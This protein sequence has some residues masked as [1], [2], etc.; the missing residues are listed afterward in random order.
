MSDKLFPDEEDEGN[1]YKYEDEEGSLLDKITGLLP[2]ISL[3][4]KNSEEKEKDDESTPKGLGIG[5]ERDEKE[6]ETWKDELDRFTV[7]VV[8]VELIL[9]VY[10]IL[11]LLGFV[12]FF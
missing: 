11:A 12:P 6:E 2:D 3:G 4:G 5:E 10:F 7:I 8:S 9:L 1:E